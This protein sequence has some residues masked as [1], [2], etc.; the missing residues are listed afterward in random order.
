[1]IIAPGYV[2]WYYQRK[3]EFGFATFVATFSQGQLADL[4]S[5]LLY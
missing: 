2:S 4:F 3:E 1:M 5:S